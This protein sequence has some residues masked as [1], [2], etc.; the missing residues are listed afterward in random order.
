MVFDEIDSGISGRIAE[1]VGR[2]LKQLSGSHQVICVTHLPQIAAFA[3]SHFSVRKQVL[4][5]ET[6]VSVHK[7]DQEERIREVALLL[8]GE[9]ITDATL[10]NAQELIEHSLNNTKE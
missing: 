9:K 1:T 7:L 2:K 5:G 8:G 10:K 3:E 4:D 6:F